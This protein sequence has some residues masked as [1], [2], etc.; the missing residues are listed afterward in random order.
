MLKSNH[1]NSFFKIWWKKRW[2]TNWI[3]F[4]FY[5]DHQQS[6]L[7][8]WRSWTWWK[9]KCRKEQLWPY[10]HV[11]L[12][13]GFSRSIIIAL[14][15]YRCRTIKKDI[16]SYSSDT[17]QENVITEPPAGHFRDEKRRKRLQ[18]HNY[19]SIFVFSFLFIVFF[20]YFYFFLS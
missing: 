16:W 19:I 14:V 2:P 18:L 5:F 10:S 20:P 17:F 11:T 3:F 12:P 1:P 9:S 8:R 7:L 4:F 13:N 6:H 15:M